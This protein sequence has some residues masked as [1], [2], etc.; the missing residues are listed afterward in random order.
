M[1]HKILEYC[2]GITKRDKGGMDGETRKAGKCGPGIAGQELRARN[3]GMDEGGNLKS[4]SPGAPSALRFPPGI[5]G[6][7]RS[8]DLT[9]KEAVS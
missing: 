4:G 5:S 6:E 3:Y 2:P 8:A 7:K 9:K 1:Q